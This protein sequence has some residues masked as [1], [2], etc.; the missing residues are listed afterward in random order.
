MIL[1]KWPPGYND[2]KYPKGISVRRE[3]FLTPPAYSYIGYLVQVS[4]FHSWKV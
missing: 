1:L 3:I 4:H 2:R